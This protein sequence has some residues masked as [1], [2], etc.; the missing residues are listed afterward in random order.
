MNGKLIGA[1]LYDGKIKLAN[2][3]E[4]DV[5]AIK[6]L[7]S[8]PDTTNVEVEGDDTKLG[9][10]NFGNAMEISLQMDGISFEALQAITG[11]AVS[12][13]SASTLDIALGTDSE[14]NPPVFELRGYTRAK[15]TADTKGKIIMVFHA[16]QI[17]GIPEITQ[18]YQAALSV[19]CTVKAY[20][21]T[22][23]ITGSNLASQR[24]ATLKS[25]NTAVNV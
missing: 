17:Q 8:T 5:Y 2:G 18:E 1:G 24:I 19:Q 13:S 10:F 4:F 6:S 16:C 12:N 25:A 14:V 15:D 11:N 7:S 9:T 3:D 21:T 20:P 23:D 22:K